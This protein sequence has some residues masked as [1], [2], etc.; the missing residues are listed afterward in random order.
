MRRLLACGG[1]VLVGLLGAWL[2]PL[3]LAQA[4][5]VMLTEKEFSITPGE[6]SAPQGQTVQITVTNSG[7]VE[8]NLTLEGGG[9]EKILFDTNLKPGETRTAEYTFAQGGAWE[10]YCP[11]DGH[12]DQ[13]MQGDITIEGGAAASG[14]AQLPNTGEAPTP[15][16]SLLGTLGLALLGG[17]LLARWRLRARGS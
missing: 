7:T 13:G 2:A 17:G 1:F 5:P 12:K 8:H 14:A 9:V 4:G 15:P 11:I 10:M 3:V 6:F 16:Y